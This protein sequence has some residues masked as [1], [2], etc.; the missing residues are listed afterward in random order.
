[1][2]RS[3]MECA[4]DARTTSEHARD[5]SVSAVAAVG[6][7]DQVVWLRQLQE[8]LLRADQSVAMASDTVDAMM[9]GSV[10]ITLAALPDASSLSVGDMRSAASALWWAADAMLQLAN[11]RH[12]VPVTNMDNADDSDATPRYEPIGTNM[13]DAE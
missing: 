7:G 11:A 6:R 5:A 3:A 1:M 10:G 8:C 4:E 9:G 13:D 12:I 2:E